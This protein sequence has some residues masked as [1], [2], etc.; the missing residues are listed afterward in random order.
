MKTIVLLRVLDCVYISS[1][2]FIT[3]DNNNAHHCIL[4][5]KVSWSSLIEG[6]NNNHSYLLLWNKLPHD[7]L[8]ADLWKTFTSLLEHQ[9]HGITC[10]TN[11]T[12][13]KYTLWRTT[14]VTEIVIKHC[15]IKMKGIQKR[16]DKL[17]IYLLINILNYKLYF[18]GQ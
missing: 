12:Q 10:E 18:N 17:F 4:Y 1:L 3:V 2:S 7:F 13:N 9:T 8:P 14:S 5:D 6:H 16:F 11:Q 15:T